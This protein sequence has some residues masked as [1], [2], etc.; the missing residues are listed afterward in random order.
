MIA[1]MVNPHT[2][3]S[4]QSYIDSLSDLSGN[5]DWKLLG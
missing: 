1:T 3:P 4:S 5:P 2:T